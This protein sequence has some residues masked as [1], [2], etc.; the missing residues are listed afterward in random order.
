M[1]KKIRFS[2]EMKD[3]IEVRTLEDLCEHFSLE[4]V[5]FYLSEGKLVTWLRDR[6]L[7]D[8]ADA[9]SELSSDD[10]K[11]SKKICQIFDV[12]YDETLE[13]DM[14]AVAERKRK[15]RLLDDYASDEKFYEVVDNIA[16]EQDDLYDLLDEGAETIYL[17]GERFS[18]PLS[19]KNV[20][21][22]GVNNPT[23]VINAKEEFDFEKEGISF[24]DIQFDEKYRKIVGSKVENSSKEKDQIILYDRSKKCYIDKDANIAFCQKDL[25]DLIDKGATT[26]YL[27]RVGK[28]S[29]FGTRFKQYEFRIPLNKEIRYIGINAPIIVIDSK[30]VIN[31]EDKGIIFEGNIL[32]DEN[33]QG[34]LYYSDD[35][36]NDAAKKNYE[37]MKIEQL[38]NNKQELDNY[39]YFSEICKNWY[40]KNDKPYQ[41]YT[42]YNNY[43]KSTYR[44]C[45]EKHPDAKLATEDVYK[46][47]F[48]I[49]DSSYN[50]K[51]LSVKTLYDWIGRY[52]K[53]PR[54]SSEDIEIDLG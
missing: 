46:L 26:I 22:I 38:K 36:V 16:F 13:I 4:R 47:Y 12:A 3:G 41:Y 17:C 33:Y 32:F 43:F 50:I 42:D 1:A 21:Y 31:F 54:V 6:Y 52:R 29:V 45:L 2:L 39:M 51:E 37:V 28:Q 35:L 10:P 9:I 24:E 7:D 27:C 44:V 14:E 40:G 49:R 11:L 53:N 30:Q 34:L 18:I 19:K 15:M 5:L 25:R 8:K 48:Y 20:R 23:V